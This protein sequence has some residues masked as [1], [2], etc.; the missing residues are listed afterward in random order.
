MIVFIFTLIKELEIELDGIAFLWKNC[1]LETLRADL[2]IV[3][4]HNPENIRMWR[5]NE[6]KDR[7]LLESIADLLNPETA[8]S[9]LVEFRRHDL[10]WPE[11]MA[12]L[13]RGRTIS[14]SANSKNIVTGL[15]NVGN[16]CYLNAALQVNSFN[17]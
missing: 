11:D 12:Q 16:S 7:I 8:V 15:I 10:S 17:C 4:R 3:K 1:T 9:I 13:A 14:R 5:I 2:A 6:R